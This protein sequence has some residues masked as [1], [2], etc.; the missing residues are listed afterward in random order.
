MDWT[1]EKLLE[2]VERRLS[3]PF[4]TRLPLGGPTWAG[5]FQAPEE[6]QRLIFSYSQSRPR[7]VLISTSLVVE[8][9]VSRNH[10]Y[11]EPPDLLEAR[12]R[13]SE[14]RLKDLG[15]EY[16]ENFPM[17]GLV[18]SKFY[19][20]ATR[21]SLSGISD[22]IKHLLVDAAV[23]R[24]C[25]RWVFDYAA[26]ELFVRLLYNIGFIGITGPRGTVFR[27]VGPRETTPPPISATTDIVIH[28]AYHDALDLQDRLVQALEADVE[29]ARPGLVV[30]V[31]GALDLDEYTTQLDE[32]AEDLGS[33]PVGAGHAEEFEELVGRVIQLCFSRSLGNVEPKSRSVDGRV[34]RD[35]VAGNR[36]V[37]GFWETIRTRY[38]ATQVIWECKNYAKLGAEDFQQMAYTST[39]RVDGS[40]SSCSEGASRRRT[41]STC[42]ASR[43]TR[44][45]WFCC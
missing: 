17:I 36:A 29:T 38:G 33:L 37:S 24:H 1:E 23:K 8:T 16:A 41:T 22:F 27:S 34:I 10:Q 30:D 11:V 5:F 43:R 39:S 18:L 40:A 15:D 12:R 2:L 28:P 19:G 9:A 25:G 4:S 45:G 20:L 14:S 6:A 31:P 21:Y 7:D 13:F 42:G 32:L 26:P 35:W 44:M 3:L